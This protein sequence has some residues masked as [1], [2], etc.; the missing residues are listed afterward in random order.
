MKLPPRKIHKTPRLLKSDAYTIGSTWESQDAKDYSHYNLAFRK[1][2]QFAG[3]NKSF[4]NGSDRIT[5]VGL[6]RII[7]ELFYEPFTHAEIDETE[8]FL[9]NRKFSTKGLR[10]FK[11]DLPLWREIVN[12]YGG[13][14][15][16]RISAMPEGSIVYPG[17]PV[18]SVKPT[19][20]GF[21]RIAA[22]F[23]ST[24]LKVWATSERSTVAR[25]WLDYHRNMI[26]SIEKDTGMS[27]D[28][29][30]FIASTRCHDFGCRA[31]ICTEES[32]IL[33][34]V[35]LYSF[36]G[37]DTFSGAYQAYKNGSPLG[38]GG[39]V[40]AQAHRTVG[41]YSPHSDAYRALYN[42]SED[43]SI[44]SQ[45][46][47]LYDYFYDVEHYLLPLAL[48]AAKSGNGKI[49]VAR[50]DSGD[51]LD[52]ILWTC[53]LAVKNGLYTQ[54]GYNG[55]LYATTLKIIEGDGMSYEEMMHID[56]VLLEKGFA[57]HSWLIYGVGG[58]LRNNLKRDNLSAKFYMCE[59]GEAHRPVIKNSE[60]LGKRSLP[61]VKVIREPEALESAITV[62]LPTEDGKDNL[63]VYYDGTSEDVFGPGQ[64]C[65]WLDI[66]DRIIEDFDVMPLT[67]GKPS[68]AVMNYRDEIVKGIEHAN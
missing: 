45:V 23:E 41:G 14:P 55:L 21:G 39:S 57:P 8:R 40:D 67:A 27:Q 11:T 31:G 48:E 1:S 33:G 49:E 2:L 13:R 61:P 62:V 32:E 20:K 24:L 46:A 5:F 10:E 28:E 51:A 56:Q 29:I 53:R 65:T 50:P 44:L 12:K 54:N 43:G 58:G 38:V 59:V 22:W 15:P 47:D 9:Q 6:Q 64:F 34:A 42:A 26:S 60:S 63:V 25:H 52:Q 18:V 68:K 35:H 4:F 30:D 66:R 19:V 17:E 16:I 37:T 36:C 3:S 7:D